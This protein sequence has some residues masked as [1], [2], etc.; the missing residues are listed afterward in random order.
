MRLYVMLPILFLTFAHAG[1]QEYMLFADFSFGT[2]VMNSEIPDAAEYF[3]NQLRDGNPSAT[4]A[5]MKIG[6]E[7]FRN[8]GLYFQY[9]SWLGEFEFE[10]VPHFGSGA[11]LNM[12]HIGGGIRLMLPTAEHWSL[13]THAGTSR[14]YGEVDRIMS[15]PPD[16]GPLGSESG[17]WDFSNTGFNLAG[18]FVYRGTR[19]DGMLIAG[20][21]AGFHAVRIELQD[22]ETGETS[23]PQTTTIPEIKAYIGFG[24]LL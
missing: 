2:S 10:S 18:G 22:D 3:P 21:E 19:D 24:F 17:I 6:M 8:L 13:I 7:V 4:A 14:Y 20:L 1:E 12:Q 9:G 23:T 15:D 16:P 5:D 11:S